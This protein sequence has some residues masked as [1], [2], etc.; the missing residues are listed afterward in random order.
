M[1]LWKNIKSLFVNGDDRISLPNRGRVTANSGAEVSASSALHVSAYYAMVRNIGEDSGG[2]P[3]PVLQTMPSGS[4]EKRREH[5]AWKLL[6][7][8]A[9]KFAG[10]MNFRASWM[11]AAPG[12]GGGYAKIVRDGFGDP[13]ALQGIHPARV[14]DS[15]ID[16]DERYYKIMMPEGKWD[17]IPDRDMLHIHGVGPT[18]YGGYSL[19]GLAAETLGLTVQAEK[20]G[21]KYY[22]NGAV[23]SAAL[24]FPKGMDPG[25][26]GVQAA[27]EEWNLMAGGANAIN[28]RGVRPL[29]DGMDVTPMFI[30]PNDSQFLETRQFQIEEVARWGRMPLHMIG[31]LLRATFNNIEELGLEYVNYTLYAWLKR[32][33]NEYWMK[34]ETEREQDEGY[35]F[36]HNT[37]RLLR[38]KLADQANYYRVM[39]SSGNLT[40][41]EVR[42]LNNMNGIG[43]DGDT[44]FIPVFVQPIESAITKAGAEAVKLDALADQAVEDT[45]GQIPPSLGGGNERDNPKPGAMLAPVMEA[46]L[47]ETS[48]RAMKAT[49]QALKKFGADPGGF[50][51]WRRDFFASH[52]SIT[53]DKLQPIGKAMA[54]MTGKEESPYISALRDFARSRAENQ[55]AMANSPGAP[56]TW[57]DN[58]AAEVTELLELIGGDHE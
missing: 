3:C 8:R 30:P 4:R 55:S 27:L 15:W 52:A 18:G 29:F 35:Y 20:Y 45:D 58:A 21:A 32:A 41:N 47:K 11:M 48:V 22:E 56:E 24:K 17:Y 44:H 1:G 14:V 6:N 28:S 23:P 36:E 12:W 42:E 39:E 54:T 19:A 34:L 25:S 33:E 51:L 10:A 5:K 50:Q 26:P 9:D 53:G 40:I 38:G 7:N 57:A 31:H 37:S 16:G 46:V 13:V 43:P 49:A 2:L